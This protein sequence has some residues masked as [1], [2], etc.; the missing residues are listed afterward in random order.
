MCSKNVMIWKKKSEIV[1]ISTLD[2]I[3]ETLISENE[4]TETNYE[5]LKKPWFS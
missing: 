2:V 5:R 3:K 1:I 4:F